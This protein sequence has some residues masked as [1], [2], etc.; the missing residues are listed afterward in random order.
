MVEH[1]KPNIFNLIII[2]ITNVCSP[3]IKYNIN[4]LQITDNKNVKLS[5]ELKFHIKT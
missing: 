2:F 3:S 5:I 4:T 1:L